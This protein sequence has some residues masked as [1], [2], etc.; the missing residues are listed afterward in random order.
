MR[1]AGFWKR[2]T[3]YGYDVII[4]QLL[5]LLPMFVFYHFPSMEQIVRGDPALS[6]WFR[7][8][9]N[10]VLIISAIYTIW[11]TA[12]PM[13]ATL[14][15]AHCSLKV[16]TLDGGRLTLP[17]SAIRHLTSGISTL[18]FGLGFLTVAVTR[19][20]TGIHDMLAFT[21]VVYKDTV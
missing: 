11:L 18:L 7:A 13:Q 2:A 21:R 16:V 14:G 19:E 5:A 8:F 12:G 17:Q 15:K 1:Y 20:K 9:G 6:Q 4:V 10:A 3:A